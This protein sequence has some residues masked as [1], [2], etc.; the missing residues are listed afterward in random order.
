MNKYSLGKVHL[1]KHSK[2]E[3]LDGKSL[4]IGIG[5]FVWQGHLFMISD[6]LDKS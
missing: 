5:Y 2:A 6:F 4:S 1:S 3:A